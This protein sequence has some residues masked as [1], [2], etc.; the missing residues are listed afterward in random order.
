MAQKIIKTISLENGA[1]ASATFPVLV[2]AS[3]A[4]DIP[5]FYADW[6]FERL[7]KGYS[8]WINPFNGHKS[9]IGYES[10]KF[11]VFWSKNPDPLLKHIAYLKNHNIGFYLLYTLN[12]YETENLESGVPPLAKRIA[13]FRQFASQF[14]KSSVI[15]RF[16]PLILTDKI[17]IDS[18]IHKIENI[19]KQICDCTEKLVFSFADI[20]PYKKV[21]Y[22]LKQ[23]NIRYQ[24]WTKD[25]MEE[26][27][28][29]LVML[30]QK[31]G[32]NFR[33]AACGEEGDFDG[34]EHN[35]CIDDQLILRLCPNSRE[36]LD[37]LGAEVIEEQESLPGLKQAEKIPADAIDAGNG[38]Y[39]VIRRNNRD[40]GQR[41]ACGCAK[42]KDIG[43]YNTCPH[44]CEYCYANASKELAIKNYR[45]YCNNP[46][47]ETITGC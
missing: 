1:E 34:I 25:Q 47:Q 41:K 17:T 36:L 16:D 18:L 11:I 15:W 33:L 21:K 42:S 46:H 30:K 45:Q 39:I 26:F 29:K 14:G 9:Y 5:A 28:R 37:F 2:S 43:Q 31:N 12:N 38:K 4:T 27:A 44:L 6:F 10:T 13:T 23:N 35:R 3:R 32:W 20:F 40:N 7:K 8:A 22:N 24:D 19:G